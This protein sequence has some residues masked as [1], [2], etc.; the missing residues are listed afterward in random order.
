MLL[1]EGESAPE[2]DLRQ[3]AWKKLYET[4]KTICLDEKNISWRM[5]DGEVYGGEVRRTK[6]LVGPRESLRG[7]ANHQETQRC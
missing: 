7:L 6:M 3:N 1:P 4:E 2:Q 5:G